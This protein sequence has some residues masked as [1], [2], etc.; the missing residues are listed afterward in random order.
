MQHPLA[1]EFVMGYVIYLFSYTL[2]TIYLV[3]AN[4]KKLS[5]IQIRKR[6][7]TFI[8][9]FIFLSITT[10]LI[11]Y[12]FGPS[13]MNFKNL[14]IPFGSAFGLTFFDLMYRRKKA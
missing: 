8:S 6:L 11:R 1:F 13:E 10:Y 3:I 5:W 2:F 14:A 12:F 9:W 4:T 7:I